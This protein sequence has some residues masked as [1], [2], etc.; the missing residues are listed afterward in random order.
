MV[1]GA[2]IL[3]QARPRAQNPYQPTDPWDATGPP[4]PCLPGFKDNNAWVFLDSRPPPH[5]AEGKPKLR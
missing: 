4:Y 2:L 1:A 5:P 3:L